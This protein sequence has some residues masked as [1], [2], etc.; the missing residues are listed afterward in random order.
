MRNVFG[1]ER[2]MLTSREWRASLKEESNSGRVA[3]ELVIKCEV[4]RSAM[5]AKRQIKFMR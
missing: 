2:S 5:K 4:E 1:D 3:G